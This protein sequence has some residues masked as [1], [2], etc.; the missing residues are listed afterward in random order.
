[1]LLAVASYSTQ[2]CTSKNKKGFKPLMYL[3]LGFSVPQLHCPV[4]GGCDDGALGESQHTDP[5]TVGLEDKTSALK[6]SLD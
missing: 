5:V 1:M 4:V 3:L 2:S 6:T